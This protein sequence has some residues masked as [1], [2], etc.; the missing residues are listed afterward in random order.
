[1]VRYD[2]LT[3]RAGSE[4][5][6]SVMRKWWYRGLVALAC[7]SMAGC[8]ER[9]NT[10]NPAETLAL[11]R[12]GR[13]LLACREPCLA[14]WRGAQPQAAQLDA[15]ARWHDLALLL[16]RVGYEDDLSLYYLGRAAEGIGYR[17]AAAGYYRQSTQLSGTSIACR[18]LSRL[19]GGVTLPRAAALRVAAI[20]RE[21]N[22]VVRPR[23]TEP[24]PQAPEGPAATPEE[25]GAP[26]PSPVASPGA[27]TASEYIEPPPAAR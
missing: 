23:R 15:S 3:R 11:L 26:A 19:C 10:V 18:H 14:G 27:S 9:A 16:V 7:A 20:E 1:V 4:P 2:R 8:A 5:G 24:A 21:L 22:A 12:A 25:A 17:A 13:P 6:K